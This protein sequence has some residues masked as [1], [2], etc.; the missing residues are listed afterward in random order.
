MVLGMSCYLSEHAFWFLLTTGET[1]QKPCSQ[2]PRPA[3]FSNSFS[4]E[5]KSA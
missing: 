2:L 3:F 4:Q 1:I 5:V